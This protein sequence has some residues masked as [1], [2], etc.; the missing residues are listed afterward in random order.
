MK[1]FI[2]KSIL[3]TLPFT[4]IYI[5]N[6]FL[7]NQRE[8]A[9]VRLGYL[10]LNP[11]PKSIITSQ[12]NLSKRYTLLSEI[13]LKEKE[14]FDMI[15]IGDSFSEQD[16]LGYKN[17]I[18]NNGLKVL[19]IDRFISGSNPIQTLINLLNSK[20]FDNVSAD[21][22]VLQIVERSFNARINGIDFQRT[23]NIDSL[24]NQMSRHIEPI[25]KYDLQ[26]FSDATIKVP[27]TNIQYIFQP[28]PMFSKTYKYTSISNNLFSNEPKELLFYQAD[29]DNMK[30]KNDSLNIIRFI[31]VIERVNEKV[32]KHK[33]KLIML[34]SPDKYDLYFNHIMDNKHLTKP[35]FFQFYEQFGKNYISVESFKI[36]RGKLESE[37]DIYFYDDSHWSPI[38]AKA[39]A[40]EILEII[41][42]DKARTHN[43]ESKK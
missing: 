16:S 2:I 32:A 19:H 23:I 37:S 43:I 20:F 22:I 38:G 12:Y 28:K 6:T 25:P 11:S 7:Y 15:T 10:Y 33:M 14:H 4:F 21:Y 42:E 24:S 5:L 34:V 29:I 26:F 3:F 30:I 17:F 27:I 18:G 39:V 1:K 31:E 13:N 35:L 41:V 9:L 40:D 36:L 8:G